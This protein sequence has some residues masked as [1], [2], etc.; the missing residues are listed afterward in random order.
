MLITGKFESSY[1]LN[2]PLV[3]H[4]EPV[5]DHICVG[6]ECKRMI[7][8]GVKPPRASIWFQDTTQAR[9]H[10]RRNELHPDCHAECQKQLRGLG[11][12]WPVATADSERWWPMKNKG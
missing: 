7:T 4:L 12:Q 5:C 9:E 8:L 6:P 3:S 11:E 10:S 2:P 1:N